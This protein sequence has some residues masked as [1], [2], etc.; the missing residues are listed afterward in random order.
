MFLLTSGGACAGE[1]LTEFVGT[2]YYMAPE[3]LVGSY[4]PEADIWSAGECPGPPHSVTV[5]VSLYIPC[6]PLGPLSIP[7]SLYWFHCPSTVTVVVHP[8]CTHYE[9]AAAPMY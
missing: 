7:L 5:L 9:C 6:H 1:V 2:P 4:G 8:L 3:V